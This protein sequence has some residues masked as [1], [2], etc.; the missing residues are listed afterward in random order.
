MPERTVIQWDKD[1]LDALGLLKVDVLALGMLTAI[2]RAFN[3]VNEFGG[4]SAVAGRTRARQRA[5]RGWR[6]VRHDL[7]R[8]HHRRVPNRIARANVHAA[9]LAAAKFLR[10]GD[11]S[12]HRA[13]RT[14]SRRDGAPVPAPPQRGGAGELSQQRGRG[15]A[16]AHVGRA[17]FSRASHAAG[18]RRGRFLA[19]RGRPAAPRHGRLEAQGRLGALPKAT[20]RRHARARL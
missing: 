5:G 8:R 19:G 20:D 11:R 1:D 16:Q 15:G 10:S 4:S 9:A 6:G 2:R 7:P 12:G 14:H 13:P 3:L 18:D 17:D